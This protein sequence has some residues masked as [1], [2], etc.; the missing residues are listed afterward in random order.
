MTSLAE[1][2]R[3]DLI[4]DVRFDGERMY[5]L[6][7]DGREISVPLWWY[8]RLQRA[9]PEQ[10][11]NWEILP[12]GDALHWPDIDEDLDVH[13]F[14]IGAKAPDA[15]PPPARTHKIAI[16]SIRLTAGAMRRLA[17]DEF[18][19]VCVLGSALNDLGLLKRAMWASRIP[20]TTG[21]ERNIG[22][23]QFLFFAR[24]HLSK[25]NEILVVIDQ[26]WRNLAVE[27][28]S[29]LENDAK[30]SLKELMIHKKDNK[31]MAYIVRN[32]FEFHFPMRHLRKVGL[33]HEFVN[34]DT[35]T[36]YLNKM[37]LNSFYFGSNIILTNYLLAAV[38]YTT[39]EDGLKQFIE[40]IG[41]EGLSLDSNSFVENLLLEIF[42]KIDSEYE[43]LEWTTDNFDVDDIDKLYLP[44][45]IDPDSIN[46]Q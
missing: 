41:E 36:M 11:R 3:R 24:L 5:V 20:E 32:E 9:T 31:S 44:F 30:K 18:Q 38:G 40:Q 37:Q 43:P 26:I 33:L 25:I 13:G 14:L 16:A 15:V 45:F 19:A 22:C 4:A 34:S 29:K 8:P 2:E 23:S 42:I 39:D 28:E 7:H 46:A 17:N 21:T 1:A 6:L 10:R 35:L 27:N 12:F